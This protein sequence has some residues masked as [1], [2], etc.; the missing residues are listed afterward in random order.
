MRTAAL[1]VLLAAALAA[2]SPAFAEVA[3]DPN[4]VRIDATF[5]GTEVRVRGEAAPGSDVLVTVSGSATRETF[6]V[7]GRI[8]PVWANVGTVSIS[9]AP[10]LFLT[11][12]TRPAGEMLDRGAIDGQGLDPEAILRGA[13]FETEGADAAL[14][15]REYLALKRSR[16]VYGTRDGAVRR[17]GSRFEASIPWPD[18]AAPGEYAVEVLEIAAGRIARRESATLRVELVGIPRF[19]ADLAFRRGPL[20]GALSVGVALAVGF[21]MGLVFRKGGGH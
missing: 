3:L 18:A 15:G 12:G 17:E 7:R 5:H 4:P 13:V 21:L 2:S 1:P 20:Y 11:A 10:S 19:V 16:G 14:L 6:K 9:G 8:G